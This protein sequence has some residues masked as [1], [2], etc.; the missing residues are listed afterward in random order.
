MFALPGIEA[1]AL[2]ASLQ[3]APSVSVRLNPRKPAQTPLFAGCEPVGWCDDG[4]YLPGRPLFAGMPE[5]HAGAFYVQDASSMIH[6]HIARFLS[7]LAGK[8][9]LRLLDLCA[10]PGGKTTA[11]AAALPSDALIVANECVPKRA[12]ILRENTVKW[13]GGNILAASASTAAWAKAEQSFDIVAVDAP[14]SGEG[15]MRKEDAARSQW[16]AAL[17][18]GCAALQREILSDAIR[19]LRPGGFIIYST[20]TFNREE[21]EANAEWLATEAG[22]EPVAIPVPDSCAAT[23]GI[24]TAIP[25]MRFMPHLTRG[26]GLFVTV[27]RKPG[28]LTEPRTP[29]SARHEKAKRTPGLDEAEAWLD[30]ALGLECSAQGNMIYARPGRHVAF[31]T[32]IRRIIPSVAPGF[33]LAEVKGKSVIPAHAA[34]MSGCLRDDAF[35]LLSLPLSDACAYLRREPIAL[36]PAAPKGYVAVSYNGVPLGLLKNLGN[37]SNNLYPA[38]WRMLVNPKNADT[39]NE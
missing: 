20:C 1:E 14:C 29:K 19:I 5:W 15:M 21:N 18:A 4:V 16:S 13:G 37:R 31:I 30:N 9:R 3:T 33:E 7:E 36:P 39:E 25:C 2:L 34:L 8:P 32:A 28:E 10:A 22:L 35:P 12:R 23:G 27:M 26:E 24:D 6:S 17:V 11:M 38:E